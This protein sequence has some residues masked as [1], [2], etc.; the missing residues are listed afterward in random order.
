MI[1][2]AFLPEESLQNEQRKETFQMRLHVDKISLNQSG[3]A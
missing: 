3:I 1:E 2:R